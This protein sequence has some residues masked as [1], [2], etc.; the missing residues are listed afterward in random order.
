[1]ARLP[2]AMVVARRAARTN[3]S[4][5]LDAGHN[6]RPGR[7]R[8]VDGINFMMPIQTD[9]NRREIKRSASDRARHNHNWHAMAARRRKLGLTTR[10]T[11]PK[12]HPGVKLTLDQVEALTRKLL[13]ARIDALAA[14]IA[15]NFESLDS[16]SQGK[17]LE[18]ANEL[19]VVRR[20]I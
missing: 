7:N 12:R 16:R 4:M 10:G 3:Q 18:L 17:A 14:S 9:W 2:S 13:L 11:V 20:A 19:S 8:K 5:C 1:M 15:R 6:P